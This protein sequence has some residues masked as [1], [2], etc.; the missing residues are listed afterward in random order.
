[1]IKYENRETDD[2]NNHYYETQY[3]KL[4]LADGSYYYFDGDGRIQYMQ[5]KNSNNKIEFFYSGSKLHQ[6]IDSLGRVYNIVRSPDMIKIIRQA[7]N[8]TLVTYGISGNGISSVTDALGRVINYYSTNVAGITKISYPSGKISKYEYEASHISGTY[9]DLDNNK[10]NW[11][12]EIYC[13]ANQGVYLDQENPENNQLVS[14]TFYHP[15]YNGMLVRTKTV[16]ENANKVVRTVF[17]KY[18]VNSAKLKESIYFGNIYDLTYDG[19]ITHLSIQFDQLTKESQEA[20]SEEEWVYDKY[21]NLV[22]YK[23]PEGYETMISFVNADY[24]SFFRLGSEGGTTFA[25]YDNSVLENST[26]HN[27]P[28]GQLEIRKYLDVDK[29][30]SE[31]SEVYYLYDSLG[32]LTENKTAV[33]DENNFKNWIKTEYLNYDTYGNCQTQIFDADGLE[34]VTVTYEYGPEYNSAYLTAQTQEISKNLVND[35]GLYQSFS[36]VTTNYEYDSLTGNQT[37]IT[38]TRGK[39]VQYIRKGN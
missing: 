1:M 35:D 29:K 10:I 39:A 28:A 17:T 15:N 5:G 26:I 33:E 8:K 22:Y 13:V 7:D 24:D 20:L 6:I 34:P 18:N 21:G 4:Y 31:A 30:Q 19:A 36:Q 16:D 11:D 2:A 37:R 38:D 12:S 3:Y 14:S 25:F 27:L 32:Q 9:V 23:D